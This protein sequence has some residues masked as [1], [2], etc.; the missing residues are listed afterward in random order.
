M[1]KRTTRC[2]ALLLAVVMVLSVMPIAMAE[3]TT[4]TQTYTKVT[5][6]PADWSGTYLI[7]SEGDKLIMDGS[8]DKLD[9]EGNKVDVTITDSKITGDYAK[10]AFTVEPMT[11]GYAIKSASGKYISG[12]S[13]SNKLNSGSTQSLNTIEL[14][15]GKV[16]VTS[17]GTTL[18]YNNAAKNGT[19]FRYY[20]SQNQ[21]PI[22]LYK[23]ETAAKQQVETPTANVADGAEIEVG[24]E[25]KFECKTEGATIYYKTA[26]TEYQAY[27]GP[28]SAS[29][30]ETYTVK[31]TKDGM[32]DSKELVVSVDVFEWVNKYVKADTIATGDQVVIYNAGNG[33]AVAGEM[34]GS[35]YLKPAA[36]TV[37]ENALT[38]DSFDKL[39]WTVTKNEDGTYSFKQGTDTTLTMGTNNGKFNLNLT[40]D[41]AV[42]WDVETCNAENASYYMSGNGLT[43][44][45]GKVYMEY[46]AKYTEFSAYCTSTDRLTEKDFGM[47]FYKL[48]RE[49][50]F[51]GGLVPPPTP[52]QKVATPTA[53][54]ATGEVEKGTNVTF[55]CATEGATILIATDGTTFNEG[56]EAT[57]NEDVTFTVKATKA[58]MDDSDEATFTYTV[59]KED[60]EDKLGKLTSA[61]Q[62][63][64]GSYVMIVSTGY[65]PLE[66]SGKWLTVV[67][68]T[69]AEDKVTKT[70]GAVW[71]LKVSGQSVT[72]TDKNGMAIAP[73]GGNSNGIQSG[74]YSWAWSFSAENQTFKFMGAGDDTVT[75]ASNTSTDSTYGG[76]NKFKAY[77]NNT[78]A[79]QQYPCE[80]TLYRVDPASADQPSGD[81]PKPGDKFVIYNQNAQAVLAEQN[82]N[83]DSPA[84]NKAAATITEDGKAAIPANGAVVFT[85]EQNGEYLRFKSDAYGYLCA[86]GTGNNAFYSKD[87]SEE[88]V[89][90][91]DADWLVRICSGGVGGYELESRT[92]KFSGHS[93]WLEYFSDS[94]KVYSMYSK[95]GDLDYT[96]YSFF[97]YPVADGVNVDG[98]LVV[99]PTI[100][101]P[102][103]MLPAYVG[104]DYEFE[105]EID[106]IYEIDNPWIEYSVK[107]A[108][109]TYIPGISQ[110]QGNTDV[111]VL[112]G[113]TTGKGRVHITVFDSDIAKAAEAG[114]TM[115]LT[116]AF[117]DIKGNE[118]R[119]SYTVDILDE[120]VI[121]NVKPAQGAQTGAEKRPEIS[122]EISNAGE[123]ASVTMT[124]NGAEVNAAYAN[125]KVTY[126]PAAAM[127][128]GKVTVTVTVKRADEKETSK[129]W[130]FTIG[131]A[132]FQRYFGQ[133]HS[134]TQYSDG[135]GSLESA[136]A[137]IKALPDNANV[138]FVAFTD[139]SNYFDKSGAANPEGALYDMTKATEYSQQTWKSY[140]D[141]V[142]AFNTE[143]AGSMVA[144]AGFEMTW[145][146]GPGHI[147]TFNTPGIVS[148]NNTTLNNKTKDAGLQAYYKLL[149]QKEGA[150]S[151]SQFNHPGTT[152]GNFIDFGYWDAVVDTRMYM[153]E[154][155]NGEGQIGAGGYYPSYEQYIMALDKGWHVAPTNN[156]DNHKGRW[157]NAN[158]ARD[159]ILTDDFTEDGIYAALRAR[160]MYATEDKNLDLDYT[161]NGNMMGSIIDVP[162]KLNFEISF[163]DPDRT[164]SIAKVELVVNSGKVAYT[165]DSAADLA[166][167]SVSVELAPEYTYYFVRVT[168]G[169]G[170][171]AVT[172]PVWVGESLKLGISK[173]ECGT[174][175]PVTNE[176]LTITTTFFNSEAKPATIKSITY[177]IG[178]ET[179]GTVTDPIALAA[180]S[181]QD[182]EFKYTP[183]KARIMTVRITAVIEQDGKEYT[184]TK[185]VKLDVLDASKLVYIG[186]DAS[187]YN[188][189]VAGNYKDSM[190]NFGELAAAY[191]VRTVTLKTSEELIAACGNS[192]YK[193]IILTAPS[194][195]LEAAQKDPKT[196]SE[197]ELNALKTFND[198]GGMVILAGWSDNYENYPI[199]QNNPNIKHMAAT[200]NEVLAKLGSS[201]RISDDAT[202]DDVR[203]AAD[204]VDKWRLYFSSYNM[205]N[206]LLKGVEFDEEHPY[207]KLYTE[208]FSHY[209]GA[210]IYAV[211]AD[212][213]PTSTLPATVSPA[214]YGHATT[215]SVDV[216]SDG[217]GG[218]A[219]PKYTFAENDDRLMVMASE[220][221]EGKGLIIVSGAAFM[222]NFEVQY[223]ASDSGA[224]KNY[225]NY[226]ICQNLV[227]MLNQ[228]EITKIADVQ[229][230]KDEGVKFTVEGIVTSNASGY[231]KDTAFFDCIY[232]Q[233]D[234]AG[235]NAFP[236]ADNFKIGDKVRVTG[237]TSSY[238]GERQ[239]AVTTKIE[240]IA[241][242]EAPAPKEVTAAQI[243]DGS[244]L[245]SLVKI[246]GTI[247]R[248]EEAEGKIQTIM[249]RD[250]AGNEA[251]VFID[252][253]ITKDKEVQNAIVGNQVEAVGLASYDNTFVLSDG[254]PVYPRI[255]IRNRADVVCTAGETPVKTWNITYVTDGGTIGG[256]YPVTY[257]EG[258]VTVLPTDVTKPGYTFLGWFTAYTGGVQ[259]K[260]IE[261]TETGD[262]TFYAHW[263]KTILPPPPVTPGTPVTPARPAAPVGLPFADVSSSDWFYNDVRYVYEKG[264]MDGT[265]ADRFSPNAPLTRAMIVTI[266]YRMA[267]SP[268][269]SGSSDFTDV[270]AGKWFA[271]AVAWAAANGIVNGYGSGL[272]GPNDPVTREQLAAILYRYAVYGGMTAVTL[273]EN[274]GS[275]ADTAQLSA[276]AIQAMNWAVGQG[277]INGSGSNLVPKAQATRA[278]VAAIIHRYLER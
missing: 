203:S 75:L 202:Y 17:D 196:Y 188:E 68:P 95:T 146:G 231:D 76:F 247:T 215:Y 105:L 164:D 197:D 157:G 51:I 152:F 267:G 27:T 245:G 9:V 232:V 222:S 209:G 214:V 186:I 3:E 64:D 91:E 112:D 191:S 28:I 23:I 251:R 18:Q 70:E 166:K 201:L 171:L 192:K 271:K 130:S 257:T 126:T 131:E 189:Y 26:G 102:E 110:L 90:T 219:T 183:T 73:S 213:N 67:Q 206:P 238:Q 161:V 10:Y 154:V 249:V 47:T 94:F 44:Q 148:R 254:T 174:S 233:D 134:H 100:T 16:I 111:E 260:Q 275:F 158:D 220:Q 248:V 240:K 41:G 187:H 242:A 88:G 113:F 269:V 259:V 149:S 122:A 24:T 62:L 87:F 224:E 45:Y 83:T 49:K 243:N 241:D 141:A 56:T 169:D 86:N 272:F 277:L 34:L 234:T 39:V 37:A 6:A 228:T 21:Q 7:V 79:S 77:K 225:S 85:V 144:I 98:G 103:T 14:T 66:L 136:L 211:D 101:F 13:G 71:T 153:V 263:Q 104:N 168:E 176:E 72:L 261:A 115:T 92:A 178:G 32:E 31:A 181:T 177:A 50:N 43:G 46:Y 54:P 4:Q 140:K 80:F 138:D 147:N 185:D 170:D 8:L 193:A 89:S 99:Q 194:R 129:T 69:V 5:K 265:G 173:A 246:K 139:H 217:L 35:Y 19:R 175:T 125:G 97:F 212:G 262:K 182:V 179:I 180:S 190:G 255:R 143:N 133:L 2:L 268:S 160:R 59:R 48:T 162:E 81:L 15:S 137:Y 78:V 36:A 109:G 227:S 163:N 84:I 156:Q 22:S 199:I 42:K 216:D 159:V 106:T 258:T 236:V 30:N 200:Q 226:K 118:A 205:E 208:R 198:N 273:E 210:S 25:I 230:E 128:D 12:K 53:S 256:L 124:V 38:A 218:T 195:R 235:I 172:A 274:L 165:W 55:S 145:S 223:Q 57:V 239:L 117:K 253:Y 58:G 252:G 167:G 93:Q 132:T 229:A 107:K 11:G 40:G 278:Q 114:S 60:G 155:G 151:I 61:D 266:L 123:N 65:A 116:F 119:A 1:K 244:V 121:S 264:I 207:D 221:I 142:A 20:K 52:T 250:A 82:D 204:G 150:N 108:D 33:Y 29:H 74:N 270:A 276:Y 237:T 184:F 96:I 63:T 135:A 120:A 127:A